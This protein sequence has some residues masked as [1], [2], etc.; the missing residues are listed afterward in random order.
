MVRERDFSGDIHML[1]FVQGYHHCVIVFVVLQVVSKNGV[2]D[3][4]ADYVWMPGGYLF[5]GVEHADQRLLQMRKKILPLWL[6][7]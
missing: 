3:P 2:R 7:N 6:N 1:L 5:V 4:I